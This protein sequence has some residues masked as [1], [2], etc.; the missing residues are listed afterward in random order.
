MLYKP[1][2]RGAVGHLWS[3]EPLNLGKLPERFSH[4]TNCQNRE[5][6]VQVQTPPP[7]EVRLLPQAPQAKLTKPSI[8]RYCIEWVVEM[9]GKGTK[10]T[11]PTA[12]EREIFYV[13]GRWIQSAQ[14]GQRFGEQM[15]V[16]RLIPTSASAKTADRDPI[17][18]VHGA[19][20]SGVVSTS[21]RAHKTMRTPAHRNLY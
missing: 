3:V 18:F 11:T 14:G 8:D 9:E 4:P 7:V 12:H 17:I 21:S 19:T 15:Y 13:G 16:E 5:E 2:V 20:R 10:Q 1:K 6:I